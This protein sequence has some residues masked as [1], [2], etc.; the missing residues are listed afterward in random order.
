[1]RRWANPFFGPNGVLAMLFLTIPI[2]QFPLYVSGATGDQSVTIVE[3]FSTRFNLYL[4]H[5]L[6]SL[7]VISIYRFSFTAPVTTVD[8]VKCPAPFKSLI[9]MMIALSF[10]GNNISILHLFYRRKGVEDAE[11]P[12]LPQRFLDASRRI[13]RDHAGVKT[14]REVASHQRRMFQYFLFMLVVCDVPMLIARLELW[15]KSYWKLD[16]FVAKNLKNIIDVLM[17]MMRSDRTGR[18]A[19]A[20]FIPPPTTSTTGS[21]L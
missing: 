11:I 4:S 15:R 10:C 7:D 16:I 21:F 18:A 17:L 6:H 3:D 14:D 9:I 1:M 2:I 12:L 19:T 8:Y 20:S 13:E 5:L